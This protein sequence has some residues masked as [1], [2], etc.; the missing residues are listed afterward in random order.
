M[1][2]IGIISLGYAWFPCEKGPSRFYYI[3]KMFAE[4]GFDVDL[5]CSGFQHFE[6]RERNRELILK[7]NYP[8]HTTF[9]DVPS[10]KKNIE[11]RRVYSNKVAAKNVMK[12]IKTQRYD[13]IYCSIPANDV[14]AVVA[15]HCHRNNIPLIIDVEDL[16]PEAMGMVT[17]NSLFRKII[18]I[19]FLRDAEIAYRFADAVIGTSDEYTQRAM[20]NQ[21]RNTLCKTIYVGCDLDSFD[22]G[23]GKYMN[24]IEKP[25]DEFWVIYAGSISVSYDIRTL[26]E[27]GKIL[28]DRGYTY[29]KVKILGTGVLKDELEVLAR[30]T[31]CTNV[32]FLGYVAYPKMAA[33]LKK[34][35]VSL[36]SF[37]KGAPQ[38][39]VNKVGDYLASG[40]PIINT[41]QSKEFMELIEREDVGMNVEPEDADALAKSICTYV[42]NHDLC[43]RQGKNA[44]NT[45][46]RY[47]DRQQ[48]YYQMVQIAERLIKKGKGEGDFESRCSGD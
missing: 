25:K 41:L 39:I 21:N 23:S 32:S 18:D 20:R 17:K 34:S 13:V 38:S 12:Y 28:L 45:A 6:K 31:G 7:Q 29:V 44:R 36:N 40:R 22:D 3:S 37:V 1:K 9:I 24:E 27:A 43:L 30:K 26:V 15:R 48:T 19:Y 33:Y 10:Y 11:F 4:N 2:K 35:D 8:F 42:E 47:F 46:R 16:W 5:V 14:A